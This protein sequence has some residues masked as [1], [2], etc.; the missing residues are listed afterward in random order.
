[1]AEEEEGGAVVAGTTQ[2]G[3]DGD[4]EESRT[5]EVILTGPS[6]SHQRA[7]GSLN[8]LCLFVAKYALILHLNIK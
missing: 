6:V 4:A 5:G 2:G 1:M 8:D 7:V 3:P